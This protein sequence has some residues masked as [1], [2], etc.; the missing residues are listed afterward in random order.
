MPMLDKRLGWGSAVV[1]RIVWASFFVEGRCHDGL[2]I[3][4]RKLGGACRS[5]GEY[6]V[7]W[8]KP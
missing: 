5:F 6:V 7:L 4:L 1:T 3:F 8:S 2:G